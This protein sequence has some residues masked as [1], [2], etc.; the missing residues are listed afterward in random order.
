MIEYKKYKIRQFVKFNCKSN[1][2]MIDKVMEF[3]GRNCQNI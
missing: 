3:K 2:N 1:I